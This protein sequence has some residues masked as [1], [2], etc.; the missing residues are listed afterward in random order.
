[1][2]LRIHCL[3]LVL[4]V[5]ASNSCCTVANAGD[6]P[7]QKASAVFPRSEYCDKL[8]ELIFK[9]WTDNAAFDKPAN[10]TFK[11][12]R[13]GEVSRTKANHPASDCSGAAEQQAK[14]IIESLGTLP[15]PPR[16]LLI[17]VT[18]A[19]APS[20][21]S[22]SANPDFTVYMEKMQHRIQKAWKSKGQS[23]KS[24]AVIVFKIWR[25][26][27]ITDLSLSRSSRNEESDQAALQAAKFCSPLPPLPDGSPK[28]VD[29]N[30]TF[31]DSNLY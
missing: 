19:N 7:D 3:L 22:V 6:L 18:F 23:R 9:D 15:V 13:A 27:S 8:G 5:L 1:M 10:F 17:T 30:F 16:S 12:N 29:V 14:K 26:G 21:R 31:A 25:D 20:R 11:V 4:I 24:G 28:A 2:I